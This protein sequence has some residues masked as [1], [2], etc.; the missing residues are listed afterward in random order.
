MISKMKNYCNFE[1][2]FKMKR[3]YQDINQSQENNDRWRN[4]ITRTK[5]TNIKPE[6]LVT[7]SGS[8]WPIDHVNIPFTCPTIQPILD[9]FSVFYT[10]L[11]RG[12]TVVW[13]HQHAKGEA[14]LNYLAKKIN[15]T[16][17][18]FQLG[19]MILFNKQPKYSKDEISMLTGLKEI[20]LDRAVVPLLDDKLALLTLAD[21]TY[22]LN[23]A[24]NWTK[25]VSAK[26]T[27]VLKEAADPN[28]VVDPKMEEQIKKDRDAR[29]QAILVRL[30]KVEKQ[31]KHIDLVTKTLSQASKFFKANGMQVKN[32]ISWLIE[33]QYIERVPDPSGSTKMGPDA[34]Y[35][36]LA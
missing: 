33:N 24:L 21:G 15:V 17:T 28:Q 34:L 6:V 14:K 2:I 3:M 7:S 12:R 26:V 1:A 11:F 23:T 10:G 32:Q 35:N 13:L 18:M 5:L 19:V 20:E 25:G 22:S 36:Y 27:A 29:L 31:M 8:V 4:E 30:M 9:S 16:M